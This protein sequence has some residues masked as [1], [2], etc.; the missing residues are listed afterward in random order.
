MG[1]SRT[2]AAGPP[3]GS[4]IVA[5]GGGKS[6][7]GGRGDRIAGMKWVK[8][9]LPVVLILIVVAVLVVFW[10][11][12]AIV[13]STVETQ[14]SAQL[15]VPANLQSADVGVFAGTLRLDDFTLGSPEGFSAQRM[16]EL[17]EV[18]VGVS[19]RE[20][21]KQP[22]RVNTV[23][24]GKPRLIIEQSNLKLNLKA[25][26][27]GMPPGEPTADPNAEPVKLIID[28]MNIAGA[29]VVI[30]PGVPGVQQEI[31]LNIP[32][33]ELK[34]IGNADGAQNGAAI[35]DVV[36]A[37]LSALAQAAAESEQLP[38]ELRQLLKLDVEALVREKVK[39]VQGQVE[40]AVDEVIKDPTRAQDVGK[41]LE[42]GLK[43]VLGG[44]KDEKKP[45]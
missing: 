13:R 36:L 35:K 12:D 24:V 18:S 28:Q 29:D 26:I 7:S 11:L 39:D 9:L 27:D 19:Y 45:N 1:E 25:L 17:D 31:T 41:N 16:F 37:V 42:K 20:L 21:T 23:N 33:L 32:P 44:K 2:A 30:R 34:N 22:I 5:N 38:P 3:G 43:D 8:I 10:R 4:R 14:A 15:N 40:K 6:T